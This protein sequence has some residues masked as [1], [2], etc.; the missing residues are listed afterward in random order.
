MIDDNRI[1]VEMLWNCMTLLTMVMTRIG[2]K[3]VN[4]L[5]VSEA[6]PMSR[7]DRRSCITSSTSQRK[8]NG[9]SVAT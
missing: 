9:A 4:M 1:R 2:G 8:L 6:K 7:S 5:M 3:I